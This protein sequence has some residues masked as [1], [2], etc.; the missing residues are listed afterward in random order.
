MAVYLLSF[1][2]TPVDLKEFRN[3]ACPVYPNLA[4]LDTYCLRFLKQ[5]K[6]NLLIFKGKNF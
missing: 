6:N 1:R 2:F 3:P 4:I 5:I